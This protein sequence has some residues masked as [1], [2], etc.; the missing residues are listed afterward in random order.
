MGGLLSQEKGKPLIRS[1][2]PGQ[3]TRIVRNRSKS[4]EAVARCVNDINGPLWRWVEYGGLFCRL[5][6]WKDCSHRLHSRLAGFWANIIIRNNHD[7]QIAR[8][9]AVLAMLASK[10]KQLVT[11]HQRVPL[12]AKKQTVASVELFS[13]F[14]LFCK[15]GNPFAAQQTG[16]KRRYFFTSQYK[17]LCARRY[18]FLTAAVKRLVR[19]SF[20]LLV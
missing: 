15:T 18:R 1:Q 5:T 14:S 17:Q 6:T 8:L 20:R 7:L 12:A 2:G 9:R 19:F 10:I 13:L 3:N 16:S 4:N 11:C